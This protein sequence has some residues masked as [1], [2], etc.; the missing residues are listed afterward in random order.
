MSGKYISFL[1][2][3]KCFSVTIYNLIVFLPLM[4]PYI[5]TKTVI[6]YI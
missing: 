3:S 1:Q 4:H 2:R 5:S 6:N